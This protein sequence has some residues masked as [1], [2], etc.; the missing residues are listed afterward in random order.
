LLNFTSAVVVGDFIFSDSTISKIIEDG[1][2]ASYMA[3]CYTSGTLGTIDI[4]IGEIFILQ[5]SP[6]GTFWEYVGYITPTQY[7]GEGLK[8]ITLTCRDSY[9]SYDTSQ[10]FL[11]VN[12]ASS[13]TTVNVNLNSPANNYNSI[14]NYVTVN[15]TAFSSEA[16]SNVS[17]YTNISGWSIYQTNSSPVNNSPT[18]FNL[19]NLNDGV[20]LWAYRACAS[21]GTCNFSSNR[22]IIVSKTSPTITINYPSSNILIEQ[23]DIK[24]N[25]SVTDYVSIINT[26]LYVDNVLYKFD[27]SGTNGYYLVDYRDLSNG[28]HSI[29]VKACNTYGKCTTSNTVEFELSYSLSGTSSMQIFSG[30]EDSN[31][32]LLS[33][34]YSDISS[35]G[36]NILTS[37]SNFFSDIINNIS[38]FF[39]NIFK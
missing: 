35:T 37:I 31:E 5:V 14:Y 38:S 22:T 3:D 27:T 13:E 8:V 32:S 20:Y 15:G 17:V 34:I 6:G 19:T 9:P 23:K 11:T 30:T 39:A 36:G 24:I 2:N 1:Q 12:A 16:L 26:S 10:I 28:K 29:Y 18:I 21:D 33:N 25:Y 7:V 4:K